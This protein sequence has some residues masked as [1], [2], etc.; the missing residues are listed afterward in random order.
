MHRSIALRATTVVVAAGLMSAPVVGSAFASSSTYTSQLRQSVPITAAAYGEQEKTCTGVPASQDGWHFVLPG[1]DAD[2]V[3]LTVTFQPGGQQVVT[4]FP[5]NPA[6]KHAYVASEKGATLVSAVAEVQGGNQTKFNLSH[7]CPAGATETSPSP[8]PSESPLESPKPSASASASVSASPS[9]SP[10]GSPRGSA[11]PSPSAGTSGSP[12][13][14]ASSSTSGAA[15][16]PSASA[17]TGPAGDS[18][19]FTGASVI[20]TTVAGLALLG[21]GGVLVA[22]RRKGAHR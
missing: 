8:K 12:S 20:G 10:S 9:G 1:N 4:S 6:G 18:L 17:S 2:F 3:K 15:V 21:V 16:S 13:P 5:G 19:A 22:R 11:S 14:S 7:T